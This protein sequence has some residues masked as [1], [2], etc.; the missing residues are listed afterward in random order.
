[1][2]VVAEHLDRMCNLETLPTRQAA[3][4][5]EEGPFS[6]AEPAATCSESEESGG[7]EWSA[8]EAS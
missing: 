6:L 5:S 4:S 7:E 8:D 2:R 3:A 1:M